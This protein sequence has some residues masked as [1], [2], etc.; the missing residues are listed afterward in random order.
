MGLSLINCI[1]IIDSDFRHEVM[2]LVVN[3]GSDKLIIKE[4]MRIA[5][6]SL[7]KV[8]KL[9]LIL[10]HELPDTDSNRDVGMGSTDRE[11]K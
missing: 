8:N 3:L 7:E 5:Q 2:L 1:G 10:C 9:N 11:L 6:I 4:G